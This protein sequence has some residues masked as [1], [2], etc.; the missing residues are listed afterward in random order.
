MIWNR[1]LDGWPWQDVHVCWALSI[2]LLFLAVLLSGE[3]QLVCERIA[4]Q[5]W[6]SSWNPAGLDAPCLQLL[7]CAGPIRSNSRR[8]SVAGGL[9]GRGRLYSSA[10]PIH[11]IPPP[12]QPA[13]NGARIRGQ[14]RRSSFHLH[15]LLLD[16]TSN[17]DVLIYGYL[18]SSFH[19]A[20]MYL[21]WVAA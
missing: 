17:D 1:P 14:R 5:Q 21:V 16:S 11:Y 12:V 4:A 10:F 2:F 3:Q 19:C 8:A 6:S 7:C 9:M 13:P 18:S 15:H 20:V